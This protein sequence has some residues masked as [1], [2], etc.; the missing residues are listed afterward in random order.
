M[1]TLI[2]NRNQTHVDRLKKL[3]AK[4]WENLSNSEKTEYRG[5]AAY[6]AYNYTDLN[7]VESA[8]AELAGMLGLS[9]TTKTDW[10]VADIPTKGEM[11]RYLSNVITVYNACPNPI[12]QHPPLPTSMEKLSYVWANSI[13]ETLQIVYDTLNS[14]TSDTTSELGVA[15]LGK[16]VLGE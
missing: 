4:G 10:K 8:V 16:M 9:L 3:L 5:I 13:E 15:V 7:R 14:A 11:E 2:T 1:V 12:D 6:G